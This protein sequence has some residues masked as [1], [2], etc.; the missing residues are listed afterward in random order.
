MQVG[1]KVVLCKS[2]FRVVSA[3]SDSECGRLVCAAPAASAQPHFPDRPPPRVTSVCASYK[4]TTLH[5]LLR[6]Y[7]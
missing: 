3:D 1:Y 7:V 5:R 2:W 4:D 6:T